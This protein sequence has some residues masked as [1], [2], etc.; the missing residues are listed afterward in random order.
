MKGEE[1]KII[2]LNNVKKW[3]ESGEN[4]KYIE[5]K[6]LI[7]N[8]KFI[9]NGNKYRYSDRNLS[10]SF[11][12]GSSKKI[13][14]QDTKTD[15]KKESKKEK[16]SL[17]K[18]EIRDKFGVMKP[19]K[20]EEEKSELLNLKVYNVWIRYYNKKTKTFKIGGLLKYVDPQLRYI[21]LLN[22]SAKISWSVQLKDNIIF[23]SKNIKNKNIKYKNN[24]KKPIQIIKNSKEELQKNK[25]YD[26]YKQGKLKLVN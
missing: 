10:L 26:L 16:R 18:E 4:K 1:S 5:N 22:T 15:Y 8:K 12:G 23:I 6:K 20:T 25:L 14:M 21:I 3:G 13:K 11:D 17:T 7:E 19:L 2:V 24:S 9:E